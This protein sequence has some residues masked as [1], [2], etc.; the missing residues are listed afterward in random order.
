VLVV[1]IFAILFRPTP[2]PEG[3]END[4]RAHARRLLAVMRED[5]VRTPGRRAFGIAL[6]AHLALMG[7]LTVVALV[8]LSF[9]VM[10]RTGIGG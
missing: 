5:S 1:W 4:P 6:A 2:R 7:V 8:G 10:G 9:R 3:D